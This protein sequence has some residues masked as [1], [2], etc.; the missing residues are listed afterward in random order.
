MRRR[1]S[2]YLLSLH[3]LTV[4]LTSK[5]GCYQFWTLLN[6]LSVSFA[7]L[8]ST[9]FNLQ[10]SRVCYQHCSQHDGKRTD[11]LSLLETCM[12]RKRSCMQPWDLSPVFGFMHNKHAWHTASSHTPAIYRSVGPIIHVNLSLT[13]T[14][15]FWEVR[16]T[17]YRHTI[18]HSS[19]LPSMSTA[20]GL[21]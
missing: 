3:I 4:S 18:V 1:Q 10:M 11:T 8:F 19:L 17:P 14:Q 21:L 13:S 2:E 16:F 5:V 12:V 20:T 15:E 6:L 7:S 9:I